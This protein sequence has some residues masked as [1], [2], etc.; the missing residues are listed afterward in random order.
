MLLIKSLL[1]HAMFK[2]FAKVTA[3]AC[4][5]FAAV[6]FTLSAVNAPCLSLQDSLQNVAVKNVSLQNEVSTHHKQANQTE[7]LCNRDNRRISWVAWLLKEPQSAQT[8]FFDLLE[9]LARKAD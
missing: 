8:Y 3:S 7:V 4:L 2:F 5:M 1:K 6:F 9:L